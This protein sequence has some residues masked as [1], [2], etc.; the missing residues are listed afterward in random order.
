MAVV[1]AH[2]VVRLVE[3]DERRPPTFEGAVGAGDGFEALPSTV[4]ADQLRAG[5]DVEVRDERSD[6]SDGNSVMVLRVWS[7][8]TAATCTHACG[9]GTP[10]GSPSASQCEKRDGPTSSTR[11]STARSG[12]LPQPF[13]RWRTPLRLM[14][15]PV[16]STAYHRRTK[17]S[18]SWV[19]RHGPPSSARRYSAHQ[20]AICQPS[21]Y[22]RQEPGA[23]VVALPGGADEGG[24]EQVDLRG[25]DRR[26]PPAAHTFGRPSES[27]SDWLTA[28]RRRAE[29]R[30]AS[31][32]GE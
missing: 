18:C 15:R 12:S 32:A 30:R 7:R 9:C 21:V 19:N 14:N 2:P 11:H 4:G 27:S 5:L 23:V 13:R 3:H 10:T 24:F 1:A 6:I 17:R 8:L 16:S 25:L 22:S 26:S 28:S 20:P 31:S 29:M